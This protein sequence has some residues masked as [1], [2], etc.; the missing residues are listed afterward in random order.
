MEIREA[1]EKDL[2]QL[3]ELYTH[4]HG[5]TAPIVNAELEGLWKEILAGRNHHVIIGLADGEIISSCVLI[6]VPNLTRD[7]RPYAFIENVVTHSE[8]RGKGYALEVMGFARCVARANGCYKLMLMT[9]SKLEA[10]RRFYERAGYNSEDKTA[11]VQ[12]L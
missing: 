1:E 10:T 11:F 5:D 9:S 6:V 4:L 7:Q 3:L 12:W 8:H 2:P